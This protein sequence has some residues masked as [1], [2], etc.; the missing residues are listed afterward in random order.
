VTVFRLQLLITV[1]YVLLL[2]FLLSA[3]GSKSTYQELLVAM[4]G[5]AAMLIVFLAG[6]APIS[7][8]PGVALNGTSS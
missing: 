1:A 7:V 2:S 4:A 6:N 8:L 5:Y 3:L